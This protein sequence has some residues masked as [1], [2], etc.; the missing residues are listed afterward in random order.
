MLARVAPESKNLG[1]RVVAALMIG[2]D[3]ADP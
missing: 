3:P 1:I 2:G